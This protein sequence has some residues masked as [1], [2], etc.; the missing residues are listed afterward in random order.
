[1]R[2]ETTNTAHLCTF[3]QQR[4]RT[5]LFEYFVIKDYVGCMCAYTQYVTAVTGAVDGF[6]NGVV[7]FLS[8]VEVIQKAAPIVH[9]NNY[10]SFVPGNLQTSISHKVLQRTSRG[11]YNIY[12]RDTHT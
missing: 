2:L 5:N 6:A 12:D 4:A 7:S 10:T 1:L 8:Q 9:P 3:M 11:T